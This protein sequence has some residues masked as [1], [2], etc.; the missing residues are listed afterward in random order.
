MQL[1]LRESGRVVEQS[2]QEPEQAFLSRSANVRGAQ[3]GS[4]RWVGEE[5]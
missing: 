3:L 1:V 4:R 5:R 2:R